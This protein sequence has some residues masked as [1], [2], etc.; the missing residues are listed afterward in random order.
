MKFTDHIIVGGR[1]CGR[2]DFGPNGSP[3]QHSAAGAASYRAF[4]GS[5]GGQQGHAFGGFFEAIDE[6]LQLL[7][8]AFGQ[9]R[10]TL[11]QLP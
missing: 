8:R 6:G 1:P 2:M 5:A 4:V 10:F 9:L 7:W 3:C 11:N